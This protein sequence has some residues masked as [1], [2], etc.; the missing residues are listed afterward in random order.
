MK[1][2]LAFG[3]IFS[4]SETEFRPL[5]SHELL[6]VEQGDSWVLVLKESVRSVSDSVQ[7]LGMS[8]IHSQLVTLHEHFANVVTHDAETKGLFRKP[9]WIFFQQ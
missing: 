6:T 4:K 7:V 3:Q 9:D 1:T 8:T 5:V 2:Y